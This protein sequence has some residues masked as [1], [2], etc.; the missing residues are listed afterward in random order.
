MFKRDLRVEIDCEG[1]PTNPKK[2]IHYS[3]DAYPHNN[4]SPVQITIEEWERAIYAT[5]ATT[6]WLRNRL[7]EAKRIDIQQVND[8]INDTVEKKEDKKE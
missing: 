4:H 2:S 5:D 6:R 7:A 8:L 1:V 3:I